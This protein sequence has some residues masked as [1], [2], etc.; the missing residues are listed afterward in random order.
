MILFGR[1]KVL[2]QDERHELPECQRCLEPFEPSAVH[3]FERGFRAQIGVRVQSGPAFVYGG[4]YSWVC[5]AHTVLGT[6]FRCTGGFARSAK[7]GRP[8]R[9]QYSP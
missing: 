8:N 4:A 2:F 5:H 6:P 1:W 9:E 7:N 3:V